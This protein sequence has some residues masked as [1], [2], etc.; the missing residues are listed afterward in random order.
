MIKTIIAINCKRTLSCINLL[1]YFLLAFPPLNKV[2]MPRI[3][4][5]PTAIKKTMDR[6][7]TNIPVNIFLL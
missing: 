7:L 5:I 2:P 3:K 1:E 4:T 6:I